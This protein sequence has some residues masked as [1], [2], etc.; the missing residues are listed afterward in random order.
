MPALRSPNAM[1]FWS[2][3]CDRASARSGRSSRVEGG[4][5]I[6][7]SGSVCRWWPHRSSCLARESA[8][9]Q[10]SIPEVSS[11]RSFPIPPVRC[12]PLLCAPPITPHN[13]PYCVKNTPCLWYWSLSGSL[14]QIL[15]SVPPRRS[16]RARS[17]GRCGCG[18]SQ[19]IVPG[20]VTS[21]VV[22][23]PYGGGTCYSL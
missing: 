8:F 19:G 4:G 14:G 11:G 21:A 6:Q 16:P 13:I 20:S 7:W 5:M 1:V 15:L 17:P 10:C 12:R 22:V 2:C 3:K 23:A 18:S 9:S